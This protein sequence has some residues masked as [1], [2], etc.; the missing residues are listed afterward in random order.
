MLGQTAQVKVTVKYLPTTQVWQIVE[1]L[2]SKQVLP[3]LAHEVDVSKKYPERQFPQAVALAHNLQLVMQG[4]HTPENKND[5]S[6]HS[7]QV[8]LVEQVLQFDEQI[9]EQSTPEYPELQKHIPFKHL[10]DP[11]Q[12]FGH[13]ASLHKTSELGQ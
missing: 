13:G 6:W 10:P 12:A 7:I 9:I 1:D 8:E 11:K 3:H 4:V 2:H 5:P